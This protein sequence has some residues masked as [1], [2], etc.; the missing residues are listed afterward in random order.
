[1]KK[2]PAIWSVHDVSPATIGRAAGLLERLRAA[3]ISPVEILVVP[4]GDWPVEAIE[5][6]RE[7]SDAGHVLAAHGWSHRAPARKSV[8]HQVHSLLLSRDA[9]EHLS[10]DR[11]EVGALVRQSVEWFA[12]NGLPPPS[13][14]VPP[15][16]ALGRLPVRAYARLGVRN[17]ESLTGLWSTGG[18]LRMLPL[19]GFEADNQFRA[20]SLRALNWLNLQAAKLTGRPIR[21]SVH[22]FDAEL[23]L[24]GD[25][26]AWLRI[27]WSPLLPGDVAR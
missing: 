25:L 19:A 5:Q 14:Y 22:P 18:K 13:S 23:L 6:L 24:A 4:E 7:W 2:I 26:K 15:A 17:V 16:W 11:K 8:G 10:R 12:A 21:V 20:V 9:A 27:P 3:G 1:M